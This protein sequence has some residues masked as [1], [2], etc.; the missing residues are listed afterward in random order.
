MPQASDR[1]LLGAHDLK[2][3]AAA[4][5]DGKPTEYRIEGVTG[6]TLRVEPSGKAAFYVRYAVRGVRRRMRLGARGVVSL[7]DA[8]ARALEVAAAVERGADPVAIAAAE[9]GKAVSANSLTFQELWEDRKA[10]K[11]LS[12]RTVV[13]YDQALRQ[14]A[15]DELGDAAQITTDQVAK[16]LRNVQATSKHRAHTVRCAIGST[17]RWAYSQRLVTHNPTLGLGFVHAAEPRNRTISG[18]EIAKFWRG[19]DQAAAP[20][21]GLGRRMGLLFKLVLLT[22]QRVSTVAGARIDELDLDTANPMWKIKRGRMKNKKRDHA[23]PL[24]PVAARLFREAISISGSGEHVFPSEKTQDHVSQH[25]VSH[26]MWKLRER[27]GIEDLHLHDFRKATMTWF[28]ENDVSYDVR[29]RIMHHSA[30]DV[31]SRSYDFSLLNGP[32]R[33]ALE[34]WER[35]VLDCAK[36]SE[37]GDGAEKV[38]ALGAARA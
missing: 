31:T 10:R 4:A 38:V 29:S 8:K 21:Q 23:L 2:I 15:F 18:A 25:S 28:A 16:L 24:T 14:F 12:A 7:R 30:P 3:R 35:Y 34:R 6:L 17:F 20:G 26:A 22:G 9:A 13:T 33:E 27:L 5:L 11:K 36:Q 37:A 32:M 19:V 1:N